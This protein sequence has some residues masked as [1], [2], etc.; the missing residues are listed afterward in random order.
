MDA[1]TKKAL[2]KIDDATKDIAWNV[3]NVEDIVKKVKDDVKEAHSDLE[4]DIAIV[5]IVAIAIE[6]LIIGLFIMHLSGQI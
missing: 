1:E 3:K 2:D 5:G 6:L 4:S